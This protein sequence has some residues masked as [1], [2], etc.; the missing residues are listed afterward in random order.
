MV[1]RPDGNYGTSMKTL[2]II[3]AYNEE[4]TIAL[5]VGAARHYADICVIDDCSTDKTSEIL[6]NIRG[7]YVITHNKNTHIAKA[8]LD[9]MK[10]AL[11]KGYDF[12]ITMDAGLSH[13]PHEI[14]MFM[15]VDNNI[16]MVIGTRFSKPNTPLYRRVISKIGNYIYNMSLDFPNK[17]HFI[18]LTSGYCRFSRK[19]II[20]LLLEELKSKSFDFRLETAYYIY[21]NG[22]YIREIPITYNY[23]NSSLSKKVVW[24]CVKMSGRLIWKSL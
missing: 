15:G 14:P 10:F 11:Q 17:T 6:F 23:S 19:A 9:G 2:V 24:D 12:V 7:V 20:T 8:T 22:L 16:D 5:V 18:D 13:D 21:N 4:D 1:F 3:P